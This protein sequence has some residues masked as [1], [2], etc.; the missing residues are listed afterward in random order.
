MRGRGKGRAAVVFG[1]GL[2]GVTLG[3]GASEDASESE[4]RAAAL[5]Q[6]PRPPVLTL[7]AGAPGGKGYADRGGSDVRLGQVGDMALGPDGSIFFADSI[8]SGASSERHTV[9]RRLRPD[10]SLSTLMGR[11]RDSTRGQCDGPIERAGVFEVS[12]LAV[13]AQGA[14]YVL[15]SSAQGTGPVLRRIEPS[16]E[17]SFLYGRLPPCTGAFEWRE[18]IWGATFPSAAADY[19]KLTPTGDLIVL[20]RLNDAGNP[21]V[22]R[23]IRITPGGGVETLV[24]A[25]GLPGPGARQASKFAIRFDGTLFVADAGQHAV[26]AVT[27]D[28]AVS[29]VAGSLGLAGDVD[30]GSE[31]ARFDTP[32]SIVWHPSGDLF[33]ADQQGRVIRRITTDGVVSTLPVGPGAGDLVAPT[34]LVDASARLLVAHQQESFSSRLDA[35]SLDGG[36]APVLVGLPEQAGS[37]DGVGAEA[38]FRGPRGMDS[39]GRG[40]VYIA[41]G[42][43]VVRKLSRR[44]RV[45]TV[46]GTLYPRAAGEPTLVD[47][48][49]EQARYPSIEDVAFDGERGIK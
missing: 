9:V 23:L 33:V 32:G 10:G 2:G 22:E 20:Q 38:R 44:G 19:A 43:D 48:P 31:A 40:N 1:I 41:D 7:A 25:L 6:H 16:G 39:D 42:N 37:A 34:L 35:F 27:P 29:T 24:D 18:G 30:G 13:T 45:T 47:G 21:G 28:G 12:S 11:A 17:L 14:V 4:Q 15:E 26:L 8:V 49:A 3:C 46:A 36:Q 5:H